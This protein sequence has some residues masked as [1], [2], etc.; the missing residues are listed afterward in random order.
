MRRVSLLQQL[1]TAVTDLYY[2]RLCLPVER[3]PISTFIKNNY[4]PRLL[5]RKKDLRINQLC[6][7]AYLLFPP[8]PLP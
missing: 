8:R 1:S 5:D 4:F 2:H 7:F 3:T 6:A